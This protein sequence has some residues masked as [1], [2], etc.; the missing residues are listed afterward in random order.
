ML[1]GL[2]SCAGTVYQPDDESAVI[3]EPGDF[4]V[5]LI[6]SLISL[7]GTVATN[8]K[9]PWAPLSRPD[10]EDPEAAVP[11]EPTE[12]AAAR[13]EMDQADRGEAR[14]PRDD[15]RHHTEAG[16]PAER[17]GGRSPHQG[18]HPA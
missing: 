15:E 8:P 13:V 3:A 2:V 18:H 7:S 14:D 5:L 9:E 11:V 10:V 6:G 12:T 1:D 4:T 17:A 16:S